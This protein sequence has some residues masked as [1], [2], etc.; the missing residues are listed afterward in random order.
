[1][2]SVTPHARAIVALD[3][4]TLRAAQQTVDLLGDDCDFYKIGL[5]LFTAEGPAAVRWVREQGRRVFLDL[6]LHDIPSTVRGAASRAADLGASLLTV[7]GIGGPAMLDAAVAGAGACGVL[8]VT[9]L[10]SLDDVALSAAHGRSAIVANEV[11]RIADLAALAGTHGV[12]C[13]GAEAARVHARQPKLRT[14]VPGVR[15]RGDSAGD[16]ARV[17]TPG[18]AA[19]AGASYVVLGR[20]VTAAKDPAA[21]LRAAKEEMLSAR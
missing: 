21:A 6:K 11:M 9:V 2:D 10:T 16:Q 8:A 14:L 15:L 17:V 3:V 12:V 7:H 20:T 13:S 19:R 18:E 5:E 1:M 4:P